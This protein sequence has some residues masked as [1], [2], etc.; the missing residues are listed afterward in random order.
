MLNTISNSRDYMS[1]S[2]K[3]TLDDAESKYRSDGNKGILPGEN[4]DLGLNEHATMDLLLSKAPA[5][6][7]LYASN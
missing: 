2:L 5:K 4:K 3:K 6:G 1:Q 7:G